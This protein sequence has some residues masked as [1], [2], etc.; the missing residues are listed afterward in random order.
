MR[1]QGL[2]PLWHRAL[3]HS[4]RTRGRLKTGMSYTGAS[5]GGWEMETTIVYYR[6][7]IWVTWSIICITKPRVVHPACQNM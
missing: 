7:Y 2:C 3:E 1:F 6:G 5:Q 4:L